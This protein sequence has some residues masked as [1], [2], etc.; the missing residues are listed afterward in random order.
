MTDTCG[1]SLRNSLRSAGLQSLL[2]SRLRARLDV[3]GSPEYALAWKTW[4]MPLGQPICALRARARP[5]LDNGYTGWPTPT[6]GNANGSQMG[7]DA[8]ATGRRPDGSKATVS[9]N[10]VA[11]LSGWPTPLGT[12]RNTNTNIPTLNAIASLAGWATPNA[13]DAKAG[14]SEKTSQPVA[15]SRQASLAGWATTTARDWRSDRSPRTNTELYE[16]KGIPLARQVLSVPGADTISSTAQTG[17][18]AALNPAHSRWLM[19]YPAEWDF[20]GATAM[21]SCRK[22][23]RRSLK[24]T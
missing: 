2:E 1:P 11:S 13:G 19:G 15:L 6:E 24:P 17:K 3:N 9:L 4:A 18:R 21:L 7:K 5:T 22:S 12:E 8:S 23:R 10:Q 16:T 20:C 14:Q